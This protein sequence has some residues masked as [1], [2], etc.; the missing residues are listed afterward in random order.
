MISKKENATESRD[1][2]KELS[3]FRERLQ[4]YLKR[5]DVAGYDRLRDF[6]E[7]IEARHPNARDYIVFH[8]VSGSTPPRECTH[9][10]FPE[11]D[12]ALVWIEKR[13]AEK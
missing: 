6:L 2:S 8:V 4:K 3:F 9:F 12:S 5:F 1:F 7:N 13:L 11:D 10:D